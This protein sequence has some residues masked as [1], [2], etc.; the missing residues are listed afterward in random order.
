MWPKTGSLDGAQFLFQQ[1]DGG[2]QM[3]LDQR[4]QGLPNGV[5]LGHVQVEF[6][7]SPSRISL[8]EGGRR[9]LIDGQAFEEKRRPN[10]FAVTEP[11]AFGRFANG[12]QPS[13]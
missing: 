8:H 3:G 10:T 12:G 9:F 11:R 6:L 1:L 5:T 13:L 4:R 2:R 7:E